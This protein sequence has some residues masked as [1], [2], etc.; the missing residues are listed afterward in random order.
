MIWESNILLKFLFGK[1]TE[2]ET[3]EV[4]LWLSESDHNKS[5]LSHLRATV[6]SQL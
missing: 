1:C 3:T 6:S 2:K 5:T 4:Q